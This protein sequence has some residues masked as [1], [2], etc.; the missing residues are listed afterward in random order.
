MA[1][2]AHRSS[3]PT[4]IRCGSGGF[5]KGA[6]QV[7]SFHARGGGAARC[8]SRPKPDAQIDQ[9]PAPSVSGKRKKEWEDP[10]AREALSYVGLD[11][12]AEIIWAE[13]IANPDLPPKEREDLIEDLNEEGFPDPKHITM[14]DLPLIVSRLALIEDYAS[15]GL[16]EEVYP[17]FQEAYKDLLNMYGRLV[18]Q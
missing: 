6:S 2:A 14:D 15:A 3:T 7:Q 11:A 10:L 18:G 4:V 5:G 17:H 12:T 1:E 9:A 16:N 13:A 8:C